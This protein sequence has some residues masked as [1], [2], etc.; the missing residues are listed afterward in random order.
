MHD[1]RGPKE[2]F[3]FLRA[4]IDGRTE[5]MALGLPLP[6]NLGDQDYRMEV[7]KPVSNW[8]LGSVIQIQF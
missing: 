5:N 7:V 8:V 4:K 3:G 6:R 1:R 2:R